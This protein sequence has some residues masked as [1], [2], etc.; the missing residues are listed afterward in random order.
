MYNKNVRR[1]SPLF[2]Q[3]L[4]AAKDE[5]KEFFDAVTGFL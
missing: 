2:K 5:K 1:K 3:K 4:E